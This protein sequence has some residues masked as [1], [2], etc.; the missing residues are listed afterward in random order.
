L[1]QQL[2]Q[3][4]E[5]ASTAGTP[6]EMTMGEQQGNK[7]YKQS[8][9]SRGS[10]ITVVVMLGLLAG[11]DIW[12]FTAAEISALPQVQVHIAKPARVG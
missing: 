7:V 8:S 6:Q 3:R 12:V 11:A 2:Q 1:E 10:T 5:R 9:W 4:P